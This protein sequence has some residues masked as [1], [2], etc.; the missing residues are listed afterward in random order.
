MRKERIAFTPTEIKTFFYCPRLYFFE[1]YLRKKP[2]V[3]RRIRMA[4][5]S[6]YHVLERYISILEGREAEKTVSIEFGGYILTGR[7]DAFEVREQEVVI[8]EYKSSKG[9]REG[10]WLS[11]YMQA[12][13]YAFIIIRKRRGKARIE[14][15]YRARTV[16]FDVDSDSVELLLRALS[17]MY[18][19][20][21]YG[22]LPDPNPTPRKCAKCPYRDICEGMSVDGALASWVKEISPVQKPQTT[23]SS[24]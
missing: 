16:N 4:L 14:L 15:H 13:T 7:M 2:S 19:I 3:K 8:H 10:A 21:K 23:G 22:I 1:L 20:K 6:F 5:G 9:P 18:L 11:D 12:L 17:D 24:L